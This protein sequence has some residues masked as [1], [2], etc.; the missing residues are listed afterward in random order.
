VLPKLSTVL[1]EYHRLASEC[2]ENARRSHDA[3]T[4]EIY[5]VMERHWTF[6]AQSYELIERF[7]DSAPDGSRNG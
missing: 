6:L 2:G 3:K 1:A 7:E 4:N 5:S